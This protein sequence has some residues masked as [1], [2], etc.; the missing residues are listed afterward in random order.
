MV[1]FL[2]S[3]N[4]GNAY[5]SDNV[6]IQATSDSGGGYNLGWV[7]AN[8]WLN[9][10]VAVAATGTYAVDVR[11]ASNGAGGV[12][13]V[14]VDGVDKTGALTV[15]NTGGWQTWRTITATGISLASGTHVV[16]VVMD[17]VGATGWVGNFNWFAVR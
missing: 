2:N 17:A 7:K 16:R 13:H 3:G 10:T 1:D 12:F 14:E 11:V 4:T 15:P 8:E 6:D 5:R 9:Y